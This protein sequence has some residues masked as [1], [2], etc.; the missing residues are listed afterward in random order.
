MGEQERTEPST[1]VEDLEQVESLPV[2][3]DGNEAAAAL[4]RAL[5]RAD[6]ASRATGRVEEEVRHASATLSD[7]ESANAH[8]VR[9][10]EAAVSE[11]AA[12]ANEAVARA[13][14]AQ[15][16]IGDAEA[17]VSDTQARLSEFET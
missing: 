11:A 1:G 7:R 16:R 3:E 9:E 13:A 4:Q 8:R 15:S 6:K 14:E 2:N 5:E 10:L 12:R 17:R